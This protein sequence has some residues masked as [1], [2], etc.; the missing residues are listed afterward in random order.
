MRPVLLRTGGHFR[1]DW[2][3]TYAVANRLSANDIRQ[4]LPIEC[5]ASSLRPTCSSHVSVT[6]TKA[7]STIARATQLRAAMADP[8][9]CRW[10]NAVIGNAR[11]QSSMGVTRAHCG[12]S[13]VIETNTVQPVPVT[14]LT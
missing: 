2:V 12:D 10:P 6:A 8:S 7:M 3:A 14:E 4:S 9:R 5:A 13:L 11:P 1:Q